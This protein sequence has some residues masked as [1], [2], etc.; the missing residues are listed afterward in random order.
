[1]PPP[2]MNKTEG[3]C[4]IRLFEVLFAKS[5]LTKSGS[6]EQQERSPPHHNLKGKGL[7]ELKKESHRTSALREAMSIVEEFSKGGQ[8]SS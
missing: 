2:Q 1:M 7:L 6:R 8:K 4:I 5:V 3:T